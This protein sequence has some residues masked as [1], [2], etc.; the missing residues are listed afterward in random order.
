MIVGFY[1]SPISPSNIS[2]PREIKLAGAKSG[3]YSVVVTQQ[4]QW[5]DMGAIDI[6]EFYG[7]FMDY[8]TNVAIYLPFIGTQQLDIQSFMSGMISLKYF[9][10]FATG[11]AVAFIMSKRGN[12]DG[13]IYQYSSNLYSEIP[14]TYQ[15]S[16]SLKQSLISTGLSAGAALLNPSVSTVESTVSS[17]VNAMFQKMPIQSTSDLKTNAGFLSVKQPYLI[18]ERPLPSV[19]ANFKKDRGYMSNISGPL[20]EFYGYTE[21]LYAEISGIPCTEEERLRIKNLLTEGV[22]L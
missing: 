16:N 21:V 9:V 12:L 5:I 17:A 10:D 2:D 19:S 1:I 22:Y 3:A 11:T 7:N 6:K 18:F 8:R 15:S 14:L 20:S 13:V 4:Y